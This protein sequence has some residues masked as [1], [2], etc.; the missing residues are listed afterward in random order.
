MIYYWPF[1]TRVG[2]EAVMACVREALNRS[3]AV[4]IVVLEN[5][6]PVETR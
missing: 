5:M 3:G 2:V 1:G 4:K 6:K